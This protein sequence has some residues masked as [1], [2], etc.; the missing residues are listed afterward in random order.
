MF[1]PI[2]F[3]CVCSNF[4]WTVPEMSKK[5]SLASVGVFSE[6]STGTEDDEPTGAKK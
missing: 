4:L 1:W 3:S 5:D 2:L 6:E